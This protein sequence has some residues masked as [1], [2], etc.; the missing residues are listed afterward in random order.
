MMEHYIDGK[1]Y[2]FDNNIRDNK[3]VR[4]S[5]DELSQK[6]FDL[7]FE[8]W[9]Q[10]GYWVDKYIPYVLLDGERV[11]SNVSVNIIEFM[12]ES[13][14]K[15]Y[16]QLGTVMTD[17]EYRGKGLSRVLME[18]VLEE[19]EAKCDAIYLFANDTVLD[20][21]AKFGFVKANEYEH[22]M[23][24][25]AKNKAARKLDMLNKADRELL[26][27]RYKYS[28]PFSALPMMDNIG[29][30]MFYCLQFMKDNIYYVEDCEAV[31]IAEQDNDTLICF[32]IFC[33]NKYDIA[34]IL[35]IVASKQTTDI[36]LGFTP[37]EVINCRIT[38]LQQE[39]TT[40]FV[41]SNKDNIFKDN[42]LMF[43]LLSHA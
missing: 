9:Y 14:R 6:T 5:F 25:T 40:L 3:E 43:P 30:L 39:D 10:S 42:Q 2:T 17:S 35:S 8:Q 29:L 31:V 23:S 11:V 38:L 19:W 34:D 33:D 22:H 1:K 4:L 28:N 21:Y 7:S 41:L 26:V 37:K 20:F 18:R 24:I 15:R 36:V 16:V 12:W 27:D 32:D 13:E